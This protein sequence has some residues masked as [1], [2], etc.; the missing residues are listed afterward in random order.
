MR[1]AFQVVSPLIA[2]MMEGIPAEVVLIGG[3]VG[4]YVKI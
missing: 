2:F 1:E 3:R 4:L